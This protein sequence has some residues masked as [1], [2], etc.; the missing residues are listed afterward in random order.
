MIF[1]SRV[2]TELEWDL[3]IEIPVLVTGEPS[4]FKKRSIIYDDETGEVCCFF[5]R[6]AKPLPEL[7]PVPYIFSILSGFSFF[8]AFPVFIASLPRAAYF[9][10]FFG[11]RGISFGCIAGHSVIKNVDRFSQA[12][13]VFEYF[14]TNV[15]KN[16]YI[17]FRRFF[18][19]EIFVFGVFVDFPDLF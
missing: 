8:P 10:N 2:L 19:W 9:G 1:F 15:G 11:L 14:G 3:G 7:R 12:I 4:P 16:V 5:S 13:R 6:V 17:Y 18:F